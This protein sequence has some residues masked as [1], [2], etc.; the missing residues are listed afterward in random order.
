MKNDTIYEEYCKWRNEKNIPEPEIESK[1]GLFGNF[2]MRIIAVG[3]A[4][5]FLICVLGRIQT[6]TA[7]NRHIDDQR[8]MIQNLVDERNKYNSV[9]ENSR[10]RERILDIAIGELGMESETSKMVRVITLPTL[11]SENVVVHA[12]VSSVELSGDR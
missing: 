3:A 2:I 9:L 11:G 8:K 10:S 5:V 12:A 4:A 7:N 1:K 6:I